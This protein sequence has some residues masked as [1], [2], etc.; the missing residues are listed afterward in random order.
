MNDDI[1]QTIRGGAGLS[2]WAGIVIAALAIFVS[3]I[4]EGITNP[5]RCKEWRG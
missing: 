3:G 1:E 4:I 2:V 5:E